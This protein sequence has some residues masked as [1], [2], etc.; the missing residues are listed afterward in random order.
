VVFPGC[1]VCTR[2]A[3]IPH[4]EAGSPPGAHHSASSNPG[5]LV[6]D[7]FSDQ[8]R[9]PPSL[10]GSGGTS[11]PGLLVP[12]VHT[13]RRRLCALPADSIFA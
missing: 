4:P 12:A 5:D 8:A 9:L 13:T 1:R 7:F 10:H 6:A 2:S 11:L 3:L